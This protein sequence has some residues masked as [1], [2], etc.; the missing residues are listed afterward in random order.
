MDLAAEKTAS[1]FY[2]Q[3]V[4]GAAAGIL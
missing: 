1:N 4:N 3:K 2:L